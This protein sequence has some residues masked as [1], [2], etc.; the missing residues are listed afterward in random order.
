M[1][2]RSVVLWPCSYYNNCVLLA[3][4]AEVP[5]NDCSPMGSVFFPLSPLPS[6]VT[7]SSTTVVCRGELLLNFTK[8]LCPSCQC[9]LLDLLWMR[10]S[11]DFPMEHS[12]LGFFAFQGISILAWLDPLNRFLC[13]LLWQFW[14]LVWRFAPS[15][16]PEDTLVAHYFISSVFAKVS[17]LVFWKSA[18]KLTNCICFNLLFWFPCSSTISVRVCI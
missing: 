10:Y 5:H 11:L 2:C 16:L 1:L 17:H 14:Y 6:S 8:I 3:S 7:A 18:P 12:H 4:G 9:I 15:M 13:S